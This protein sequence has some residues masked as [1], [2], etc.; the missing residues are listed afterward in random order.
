MKKI[1]K[2][3]FLSLILF[4]CFLVQASEKKL[5]IKSLDFT[6]SR[7]NVY[8]N[9]LFDANYA[10]ANNASTVD[11][12]TVDTITQLSEKTTYLLLGNPGVVNDDY[13]VYAQ[14]KKELFNLRYSPVIP[15]DSEGNADK[16]SQE[17]KDDIA[18]GVNIPGMFKVLSEKNILYPDK[19]V[20]KVF[21]TK[22][23]VVS[24]TVLEKITI[25]ESNPDNPKELKTVE[26]NLI[27]TYF[28][29]Q[30]K[31][32]YKLYWIMAE[33]NDDISEFI[34]SVT[35]AETN[36]N[37]LNNKYYVQNSLYNYAALNSLSA[38]ETD[39][40]YQQ[41]KEKVVLLDTYYDKSI[42]ASATGFFIAPGYIITTWNYLEDS[43]TNG[44]NIIISDCNQNLYEMAGIVTYS[45]EL[46]IAIIKLTE[47]VGSAPQIG[48]SN[49]L[50]INDPIIALSSK[51]GQKYSMT[52]GIVIDTK[53][54]I[55]S[56]LPISDSDQGSP[57]FNRHGD[58][59]GMATADSLN[60]S[61]SYGLNSEY[62]T[63][64]Q[65]M[66]LAKS[67]TD[68]NAVT[69]STIKNNYYNQ[70]TVEKIINNIPKKIWD[71]YQQIGNIKQNITLP[72]TKANYAQGIVSLRYR[73]DIAEYISSMMIAE[74]FKEALISDG[75]TLTYN[76]E[77]K[78]I[79][80]NDE[81]LIMI[82]DEIK[83]LIVV[84][85]RK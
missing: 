78:C 79:Y 39:A 58:I 55:K 61:I 46:D 54:Q 40:I 65:T 75:Y 11:S 67:F 83:S 74:S 30:D 44:Q 7:D 34:S 70:L 26:T 22:D 25:E 56:S 71:K 31:D 85:V 21:T 16:G 9:D 14:R 33:T 62:L 42:I 50:A 23:Y 80:E 47:Q 1:P 18:T 63:T 27:L 38:T 28:Y 36:G 66:L 48:N 20:L 49:S 12:K 41:N 64:V 51:T 29:K 77:N 37:A 15:L 6:M 68:V 3:I 4:L 57:L 43:L 35:A 72:L 69:Y 10:I 76:S 59:I 17:Y 81:Y 2:L 84:M 82:L 52:S 24:R 19:G 73:N 60:S 5:S 13:Q 53:D 8:L 32:D 45:A